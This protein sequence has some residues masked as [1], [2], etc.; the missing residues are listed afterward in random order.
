MK[1][2]DWV[3]AYSSRAVGKAA[4]LMLAHHTQRLEHWEGRKDACE[5]EMRESGIEF[6]E[7]QQTGGARLDVV[8][9]AELQKRYQEIQAKVGHH[10]SLT[11]EFMGWARV[12]IAQP[13][14]D[15]YLDHDDVLFF[16]VGL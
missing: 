14:H 12:L 13:D 16:K 2:R 9:D 4:E 15:I 8:I 7:F 11:A 5:R 1:R 10:A 3:Y 6:R